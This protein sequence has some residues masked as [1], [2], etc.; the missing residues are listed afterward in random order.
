MNYSDLRKQAVKILSSQPEGAFAHRSFKLR[1]GG[2]PKDCIGL[3]VVW[4]NET[5]AYDTQWCG[6]AY[7]GELIVSCRSTGLHDLDDRE[8]YESQN[9]ALFVEERD[10]GSPESFD[11]C[12]LTAPRV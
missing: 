2:I 5:H 12:L 6:S 10:S 3:D 7:K 4:K 1:S 11:S 9:G 8:I